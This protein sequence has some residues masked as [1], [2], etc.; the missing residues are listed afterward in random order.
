M[1]RMDGGRIDHRPTKFRG[2]KPSN[3]RLR[4]RD[5][6]VFDFTVIAAIDTGQVNNRIHCTKRRRKMS[7]VRRHIAR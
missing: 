1:T 3:Q 4:G 7:Q 6:A 5:I 2:D